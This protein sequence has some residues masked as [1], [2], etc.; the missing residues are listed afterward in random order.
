MNTAPKAIGRTGVAHDRGV[1]CTPLLDPGR[2]VEEHGDYLY[3][4]ALVRVRKPDAAEDLVQETFLSAIRNLERFAGQSSARSWLCGILEK[5]SDHFRTLTREAFDPRDVLHGPFNKGR[6]RREVLRARLLAHD[7]GPIEW[8][9]EA[10]I[11][12]AEFWKILQDCLGKLPERIAA[13][14]TLR[15][16]DELGSEEICRL[17]AISPSNLWVMLHRAR[18]ALRE[19]LEM[20]WF[21]ER[22][23][24]ES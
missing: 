6:R 22:S 12:E 19:C 20:N 2:W 1:A 23:E 16:M 9:P 10:Q 4:Y 21:T 14:F 15:E 17:L 5:V 24:G 8:K 7:A 13:V 18:T 3:R 11:T